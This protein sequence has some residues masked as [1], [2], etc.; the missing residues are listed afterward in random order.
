MMMLCILGV[1][2]WFPFVLLRSNSLSLKTAWKNFLT[3][4]LLANL[5]ANERPSFCSMVY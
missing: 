5:F 2:L 3:V 4:T 1:S